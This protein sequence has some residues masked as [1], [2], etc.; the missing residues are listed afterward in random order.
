M[1]IELQRFIQ[2]VIADEQRPLIFTGMGVLGLNLAVFTTVMSFRELIHFQKLTPKILA[3]S[4]ITDREDC[5]H[6]LHDVPEF[7]QIERSRE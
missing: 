2:L 5:R 1:P 3:S 4:E 6:L 7:G